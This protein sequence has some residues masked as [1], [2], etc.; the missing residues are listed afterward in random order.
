[1]TDA[2]P[3]AS[4]EPAEPV[5][6]EP[7]K[8]KKKPGPI[9]PA[10]FIVL[11][12]LAA[13]IFIPVWLFADPILRW[14][15]RSGV[16]SAG[17]QFSQETVLDTDALGGRISL[18]TMAMDQ[19]RSNGQSK[20]IVQ[21]PEMT[22]DLAVWDTLTGSD[23]VIERM[24]ADNAQV[25]LRRY[26]DGR[27][28]L[29]PEPVPGE[30]APPTDWRAWWEQAK[31]WRER[32]GRYLG[33]DQ[34][35]SEE[36]KKNPPKHVD[37]RD[38][39]RVHYQPAPKPGETGSRVLIKELKITGAKVE[40]PESLEAAQS[41]AMVTTPFDISSANL[42]GSNISRM[43]KADERMK[44]DG[45]LAT[46]G[47]GTMTLAIDRTATAGTC[48]LDW[49]G[50]ALAALADP[51]VAPETA[52]WGMQGTSTLDLDLTWDTGRLDG[53]LVLD[54]HDF[55]L[56]PTSTAPQ[57]VHQA[58]EGLAKANA[59]YAKLNPGK[60]L[61]LQWRIGISGSPADL[62]LSGAGP[63]G[64]M[65]AITTS[66]KQALGAATDQIKNQAAEEG[67]KLLQGVLPGG[68]KESGEK[69]KIELPKLPFQK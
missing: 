49:P 7:E 22:V 47:A 64:L 19:L 29:D 45:T 39:R 57:A 9:R 8:P 34:G 66:L 15:I 58:A 2:A 5:A 56:S 38:P 48:T 13:L 21:A 24:V 42:I 16:G 25:I 30:A 4:P 32:L 51:A 68:E 52:A 28:P 12:V 37:A 61:P 59:Q 1:M 17:F 53:Q 6:T 31:L 50:L 18:T 67:K 69:P 27:S 41:G 54:L 23:I 43:L 3:S 36:E 40:L 44:L 33:D 26:K 62:K 63:E 20:R 46:R 65:E 14:G 60:K 55:S 10:G 35:L 11:L